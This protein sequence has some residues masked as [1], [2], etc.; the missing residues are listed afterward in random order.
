MILL[1]LPYSAQLGTVRRNR[2]CR[3]SSDLC[4]LRICGR[5]WCARS[6]V[7]GFVRR[8]LIPERAA[9][10]RSGDADTFPLG[11]KRGRSDEESER[12]QLPREGLPDGPRRIRDDTVWRGAIMRFRWTS[13]A[14]ARWRSICEMTPPITATSALPASILAQITPEPE[15]VRK[16]A[17][18]C[19]SGW[20]VIRQT[21]QQLLAARAAQVL[22]ELR[23]SSAARQAAPATGS[24]RGSTD[25]PANPAFAGLSTAGRYYA[26]LSRPPLNGYIVRRADLCVIRARVK[27]LVANLALVVVCCFGQ[28]VFY[29][30]G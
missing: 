25:A 6:R 26:P 12:L 15:R 19:N 3:C 5:W 4:G 29:R 14:P 10:L 24:S 17:R 13:R 16:L 2:A 23:R 11:R 8:R 7:G 21:V 27:D 1:R 9:G 28:A 30:Q 20:W 18:S 22:H